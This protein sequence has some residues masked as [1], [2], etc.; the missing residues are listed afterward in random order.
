M[1]DT[2]SDAWNEVR[3]TQQAL[4]VLLEKALAA[5]SRILD[6][7]RASTR[8]STAG[9]ETEFRDVMG[10]GVGDADQLIGRAARAMAALSG[11][12]S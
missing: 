8:A 12:H 2:M 1:K 4:Q 7:D 9:A 6:R 10:Y 5:R 11:A 3:N